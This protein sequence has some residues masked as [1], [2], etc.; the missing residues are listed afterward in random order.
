MDVSGSGGNASD[1]GS[2]GGGPTLRSGGMLK[3][4]MPALRSK[5]M[6]IDP[7][8]FFAPPLMRVKRSG[9]QPPAM[10]PS[11]VERLLAIV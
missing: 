9:S 7:A 11:V 2:V 1:S 5:V 3:N 6:R 10:L 8:P 4:M